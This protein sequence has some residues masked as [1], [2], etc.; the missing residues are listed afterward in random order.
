MREYSNIELM[1][2]QNKTREAIDTIKH[3]YV[4]YKDHSLA[5]EILWLTAKTYMKLDSNRQ[6]LEDLKI[7]KEKFHY[8]ILGDDALFM[9]GKLYQEKLNDKEEA[10]K[11][12]QE[13]L[14]KYPGSIFI[15]ESRKR[16]RVLRG[17]P[18]N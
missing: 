10:M 4:K 2:F 17:D 12:Y 9:M 14:E 8:D 13:L 11:L 16:F 5:D 3:L 6:A 7:I 15:A 1:L 18:I